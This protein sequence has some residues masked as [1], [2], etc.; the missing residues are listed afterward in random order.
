MY[1]ENCNGIGSRQE[2]LWF[3]MLNSNAEFGFDFMSKKKR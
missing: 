3:V 2:S 1:N